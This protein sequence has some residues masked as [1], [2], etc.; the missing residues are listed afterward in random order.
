MEKLKGLILFVDDEEYVLQTL[1]NIFRR[2]FPNYHKAFANKAEE[3][4][5]ILNS[6][7]DSEI[8]EIVVFSDWLMPGMTGT[9]LLIA[10][11]EKYPQ[12]VNFLLSGMIGTDLTK[13]EVQRAGIKKI[14]IKPWSN[15]NLMEI[16]GDT[17]K[18]A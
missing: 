18:H 1:K 11:H 13:D 17:L 12:S 9:E 4:L 6:F 3:A 8:E 15:Q 2:S 5:E 10:I 16:L 7:D 14:L